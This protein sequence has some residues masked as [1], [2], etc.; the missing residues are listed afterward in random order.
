MLDI[1]FIRENPSLIKKIAEK[2]HVEVD[3]DELLKVD[4]RKI[5]LEKEIQLLNQKRNQ[6]A[7]KIKMQKG[8]LDD[9]LI[10]EGRTT[11]VLV[12][13]KEAELKEITFRFRELM[14]KVPNPPSEGTPEGIDETQNVEVKKVGEVPKFDFEIM[15]HIEL[16]KKHDLID[17]ERGVKVAGFR[18]YYLKNEAALMHMGLMMYA[19]KKLVATGYTPMIPPSLIR[20]FT[21]WGTGY[22]PFGMGDNY[23]MKNVAEEENGKPLNDRM[24]LAGT[25][26]VG[27][28]A[29][30]AGEVLEEKQL[31]I[32]LCGFSP[33]YRREIGS[34]GK[35]TRGIYRLHEFMKVEQFIIGKSDFAETD[36]MHQELI[37]N[38]ENFLEELKMPYRMIRQ[39]F[40]D[41][42][43]G[44]WKKFDIEVWMPSRNAYGETH[45]ASAFGE[46]QA[47]RLSI[48]YIDKNGEKKYV[49]TLNNTLIASPRILIPIFEINQQKDGSIKVPEILVPYLG[50]EYIGR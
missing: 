25:A 1:K 19:L 44:Q 43:A 38:S 16:A 27:L 24:F 40:G 17:F 37:S 48:K 45:S 33:C 30:F 42:G 8:K 3:I 39:C 6:I 21:L 26:E 20:E 23:E 28:G 41:M 10:E 22:F 34:Y 15:D 13:E 31:P 49:H 47:R 11:K 50:K 2:K 7:N 29:Y 14:L 4:K 46:W 35:D 9:E 12:S 36:R 5:E 32:K 18:G